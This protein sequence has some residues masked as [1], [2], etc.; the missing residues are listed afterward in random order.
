[1]EVRVC[2]NCRRLFKYI[3]GA[4]LCQ[5][6]TML[7]A[8]DKF[9]QAEQKDAIDQ[10]KTSLQAERTAQESSNSQAAPNSRS[11]SSSIRP[12]VKDEEAKFEQI[13][14]YIMSHPK[15]T[16]AQISEVND[17][18]P[19]KLF[20]WIRSERLEF[21]EDSEYAWFHCEKCGAKIRSG[22]LCNRCKTK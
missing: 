8:K 10:N 21:S 19:T 22:R 1:M 20:E 6:C 3:Y 9:S 15:A 2:K 12:L 17:I 18:P 16:V 5:D 4:E 11:L 14:D 13:R 7:L